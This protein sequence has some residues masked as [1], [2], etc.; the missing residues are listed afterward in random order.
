MNRQT[1][2]HP[3][4]ARPALSCGPELHGT[5]GNRL[6]PVAGPVSAHARFMGAPCPTGPASPARCSPAP[7]LPLMIR[8]IGAGCGLADATAGAGG[9]GCKC[10]R[11]VNPR[12]QPLDSEH[13]ASCPTVGAALSL[14]HPAQFPALQES[15]AMGPRH[16]QITP[17]K[18]HPMTVRQL[19]RRLTGPLVHPG[20]S[21]IVGAALTKGCAACRNRST[22]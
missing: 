19:P 12:R 16:P 5:E 21:F 14:F 8:A 6:Q 4:V 1:L 13:P 3:K 2:F 10:E 20:R 18:G 7:F 9:R 11:K 15:R 17:H 22:C